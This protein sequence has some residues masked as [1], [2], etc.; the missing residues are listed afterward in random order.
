MHKLIGDS[1]RQLHDV[2]T[3]TYGVLYERN[4][5]LFA[6]YFRRIRSFY[7][8]GATATGAGGGGGG[9]AGS[10]QEATLKFFTE[11]YR[12]MFQVS[13]VRSMAVWT[14]DLGG[15]DRYRADVRIATEIGQ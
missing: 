5:A 15:L 14:D 2:F 13:S 4:S 6:D 12:K 9:R 8:R 7:S 1:Q 10:L 3:R 11:L